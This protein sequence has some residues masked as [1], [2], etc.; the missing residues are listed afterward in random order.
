MNHRAILRDVPSLHELCLHIASKY[1]VNDCDYRRLGGVQLPTE[2]VDDLSEYMVKDLFLY[3]VRYCYEVTDTNALQYYLFKIN[4][5]MFISLPYSTY[6]G[7]SGEEVRILSSSS[8]YDDYSFNVA[9]K[10]VIVGHYGRRRWGKD[11]VTICGDLIIDTNVGEF[12]VEP[13][14]KVTTISAPRGMYKMME[15]GLK[16]MYVRS[17]ILKR[18]VLEYITQDQFSELISSGIVVRRKVFVK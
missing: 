4:R 14:F 9:K 11:N 16:E 5:G 7:S 18:C 10:E 15:N 3:E 17:V 12:Y 8:K 6:V 13:S 1:M 2:I